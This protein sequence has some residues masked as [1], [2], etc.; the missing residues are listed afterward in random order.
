M[1][2]ATGFRVGDNE[3]AASAFRAQKVENATHR[4]H[5]EL[6]LA[7]LAAQGM[8]SSNLACLKLPLGSGLD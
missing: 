6:F 5:R 4:A 8:P 7:T 2:D 3:N 1:A